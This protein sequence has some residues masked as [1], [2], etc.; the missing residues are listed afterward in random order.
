[1]KFCFLW[2]KL[3]LIQNLNPVL[4]QTSNFFISVHLLL[5][6]D[7]FI[8]TVIVLGTCYSTRGAAQRHY[9]NVAGDASSFTIMTMHDTTNTYDP[10]FVSPDLLGVKGL[11]VAVVDDQVTPQA[12]VSSRGL[13]VSSG[14]THKSLALYK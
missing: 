9:A 7:K 12:A 8:S 11:T 1:M 14:E 4:G 6:C 3:F 10:L 13:S 5:S 2:K